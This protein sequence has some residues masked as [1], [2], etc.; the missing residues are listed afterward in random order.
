MTLVRKVNLSI[1]LCAIA[2]GT[3]VCVTH[4]INE[5][6]SA[7]RALEDEGR[8]LVRMM[9]SQIAS[10]RGA[11]HAQGI[12]ALINFAC[13]WRPEVT[14]FTYYSL[15]IGGPHVGQLEFTAGLP[16]K[17]DPAP[18][19]LAYEVLSTR[20]ETLKRRYH[21]EKPCAILCAPISIGGR[22]YGVIH[23][24]LSPVAAIQRV[25]N[26]QQ[27]LFNTCILVGIL[28]VLL[29]IVVVRFVILGRVESL[30]HATQAGAREELERL[31]GAQPRDEIG[32]LALNINQMLRSIIS[33]N[34]VWERL[35]HASVQEEPAFSVEPPVE[36]EDEMAVAARDRIERE[37]EIANRIQRSL[38]PEKFPEN[39]GLRFAVRYAP[40]GKV[41]GDL[42]DFVQVD[43]D[44][45]GLMIA[46]VAGHG[47]PAA[48]VAG[49]TKI[50][51]TQFSVHNPSPSAVVSAINDY[52]HGHLRTG[53]YVTIFYGIFNRADK[54]FRFVRAGHQTPFVIRRDSGA[55][56]P[57]E[58]G[59]PLVGAALKMTFEES[60]I[61]LRPGDQIVMMTDGLSECKN[62][63]GKRLGQEGLRGML[64]NLG[65]ANAEQTAAEIFR[66]AAEFRGDVVP[67]DDITIV[68]AEVAD[69]QPAA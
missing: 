41:G 4:W 15:A 65:A 60:Q 49:M 66:Q 34:V 3:A 58:T 14:E 52:L 46:D 56:E 67:E 33:R 21:D 18:P 20:R 25:K 27:R 63:Q 47:I 38:L 26:D 16:P 39:H 9:D 45:L 57:L 29:I 19:P 5:R 55:L 68:V 37:L 23:L 62:A 61:A 28:A 7:L 6:R 69:K 36:T 8:R 11:P 51:F 31:G 64:R 32:R 22:M 12:Q 54:T 17:A 10:L 42:Y 24:V 53:H 48:F 43:A 44:R 13:Q 50:A 40:A 2:A 30:T 1:V 35:Y 59:G